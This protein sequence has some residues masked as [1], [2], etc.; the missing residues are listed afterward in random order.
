MCTNR[1]ATGRHQGLPPRLRDGDDAIHQYLNLS[2]FAEQMLVHENAVVKVANELPF[3]QA[4]LLGCGVTTGLG[5]VMNTAEVRPRQTV[6]V[7]GC[8]GV[9][10]S[11]VQGARISGASTIIAIDQIR[12]KLELASRLGATHT[13][14]SSA[15][16]A[17]DAVRDLTN[18]IGV[19]HAFEAIGLQET[20]ELAFA[21]LKR[22]GTA[23]VIGVM[24]PGTTLAIPADALFYERKLQGSNMGSTRFRVD[25]PRYTRMYLDGR[26]NLDDMVTHRYALEDINEG[27]ANMLSGRAARN[28]VVM[29]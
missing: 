9:G 8:G 27:F 25:I 19:D 28:V 22:G 24:A 6:A 10:L 5:A 17:A 16:D 29:K 18:G 3:E 26:L 14:D 15:G 4:A 12:A 21:L 20:A 13:I 11:A 1:A 7:V 2:S 23:T